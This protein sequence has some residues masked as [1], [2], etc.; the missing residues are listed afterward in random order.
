MTEIEYKKILDAI[1]TLYNYCEDEICENC[2]AYDEDRD[3]CI[4]ER[5]PTRWVKILKREGYV[6]KNKQ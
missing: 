4:L 6:G 2:I 3:R 5:C 1:E